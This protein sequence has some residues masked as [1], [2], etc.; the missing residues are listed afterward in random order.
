MSKDI[1]ST[2]YSLSS[3]TSGRQKMSIWARA[4]QWRTEVVE[5]LLLSANHLLLDLLLQEILQR[6]LLVDLYLVNNLLSAPHHNDLGF[7]RSRTKY[8][9]V[10]IR[11]TLSIWYAAAAVYRVG[12]WWISI[13]ESYGT[14]DQFLALK[15]VRRPILTRKSLCLG[16]GGAHRPVLWVMI[17][18][19]GQ[20]KRHLAKD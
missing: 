3:N 17:Q 16:Q 4:S 20:I 7:W 8:H 12:I 2:D 6:R 9:R 14:I 18:V 11:P 13:F 19:R 10:C 1:S 15:E 5:S